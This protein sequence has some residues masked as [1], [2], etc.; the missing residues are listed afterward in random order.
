M[1][2]L[3][4]ASALTASLFAVALLSACSGGGGPATSAAP[5]APAT[6]ADTAVTTAPDASTD[7]GGGAGDL[8]AFAGWP[9]Q[10]AG[11]STDDA[12][13][14]AAAVYVDDASNVVLATAAAGTSMSDYVSILTAPYEVTPNATCGE[15]SGTFVCYVGFSDNVVNF[16]SFKTA[17][18]ATAFVTAFLEAHGAGA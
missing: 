5:D 16:T 14:P 6:N 12:S 1:S 17:D 13:D 2:L 8:G 7:A 11:Y 18:E 10:I 4:R 15:F 3:R 9:A